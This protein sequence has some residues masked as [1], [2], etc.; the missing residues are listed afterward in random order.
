MPDIKQ[1]LE[2]LSEVEDWRDIQR[3]DYQLSELL[4]ISLCSII[5]LGEGYTD[6]ED[7][8]EDYQDWLLNYLPNLS[9]VPSHDTFRN[10]YQFLNKDA[11]VD[12]LLSWT[13]FIGEV[14]EG[15]LISIDGKK[16][17]GVP[18]NQEAI[19]LVNAWANE[20]GLSLGQ[21]AIDSKSN[22][23]K[24]I[25]K[26]LDMI[27][28]S[29]K[30]IRIDAI[31]T[32]KEIASQIRAGQGDY[33]LA[34]KGNQKNLY[35]EVEQMFIEAEQNQQI[36]S[37]YLTQDKGHG[38]Q[39]ERLCSVIPIKEGYQQAQKW[40]DAQS[41]IRVE[42]FRLEVSTGKKQRQTHYYISSLEANARVFSQ[43]IR[44]HWGIENSLHWVLDVVMKEDD[45]QIYAG[46]GAENMA[47]MRKLALSLLK[48]NKG[49][50][51]I[52]RAMKRANRNTTFLENILFC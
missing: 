36:A 47:T 12:L 44:G 19:W 23:I 37:S 17:R 27:D 38:R 39:E 21:Q 9:G 2:T 42:S 31:G 45:C 40:Q 43:Y 4:F 41:Y 10:I 22:E 28:L 30:V 20:Q 49:S 29:G 5:C 24:A 7:F 35:W 6:M 52:K 3:V 32:Q 25:P 51:S 11:F 18:N 1:I 50:L 13:S 26:L 46:N 14:S 16:L 8:A 15:S 48:K 33:V 34:V